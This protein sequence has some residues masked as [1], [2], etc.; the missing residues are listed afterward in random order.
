MRLL[1]VPGLLAFLVVLSG[2]SRTAEACSCAGTTTPCEAYARDVVFIGE[3]LSAETRGDTHHMR[4]AVRRAYKGVNTATVDIRTDTSTCGARLEVGQRYLVFTGAGESNWIG[5]C[6]PTRWIAPGEPDPE[7]PPKP[8]HIYGTVRMT[9]IVRTGMGEPLER[10]PGL[11]VWVDLPSGPIVTETD[12]WG[13]F[14]LPNVPPGRHEVRADAGEEFKA[15]PAEVTLPDAAACADTHVY[16]DHAGRI[17]GTLVTSDGRPAGDVPIRLLATNPSQHMPWSGDAGIV[18]GRNTD[19]EGR[20]VFRDLRAGQYVLAVNPEGESAGDRPYPPTFYGGPTRD[21]A[22]RITVGRGHAAALPAPFV[23]PPP[24]GTRTIT[25]AVTCADGTLPDFVSGEMLASDGARGVS[26]SAEKTGVISLRIL[27]GR[28][29][30]LALTVAIPRRPR[31]DTG[32]LRTVHPLDPWP[33]AAGTA[34][35]RL[36]IV[37]PLAACDGTP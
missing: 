14:T 6:G 19:A 29:F 26:T 30:S 36:A 22:T 32:A 21:T 5:L 37:A 2:G 35:D 9:D 34:D 25:V 13:R 31:P 33:I 28:P 23:L 20:F 15:D 10:L 27:Q 17:E 11:R 7:M 24:L 8:G 3:V 18:N 12:G 16:V 1:I 4:L